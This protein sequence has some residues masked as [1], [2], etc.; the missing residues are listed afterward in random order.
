MK[1][2]KISIY[3]PVDKIT[4]PLSYW[5]FDLQVNILHAD[6]S[7]KRLEPWWRTWPGMRGMWMT[8]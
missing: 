6:I 8:P 1:T 3:Y 2:I 5:E 7:L 4:V